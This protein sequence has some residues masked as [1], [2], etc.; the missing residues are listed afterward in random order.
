MYKEQYEN[1]LN[2]YLKHI[3]FSI[4]KDKSILITGATGLI[5]SYLIDLLIKKNEQESLNVNIYAVSR[6][7][8]KLKERFNHY[9]ENSHF[10]AV[11]QDVCNPFNLDYV[12]YIIHGASNTHPVAYS[13]DPVGTI[14]TNVLGLYNLLNLAVEK[15]VK[16]F[17]FLSSVEIYGENK[18]DKE[19]F[20]ETDFGYIDCNTLRAGYPES[21]RLGESLCQAYRSKYGLDIVIPRISRVYGPTIQKSDTKALSQFINNVLEDKDIVLKSDGM[22][23]YSYAYVG[24]VVSAIILLLDKGISGEAYN[25]A[26]SKSDIRLKDL[27]NLIASEGNKKVIFEL[28]NETEQKGFSKATKAIIDPRKLNSLGF[29]AITHIEEGISN[30]IKM[31]KEKNN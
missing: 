24:D 1:D 8:N 28:P 30:T 18:T 31:L 7:E 5:G 25:I 2:K 16:R 15:Q 19:S 6:N 23:H 9:Y 22:Q 27:A 21:K 12:D 26:D 4:F 17:I 10:H 20:E 29:I 14:T 13:T 11:I 3:D